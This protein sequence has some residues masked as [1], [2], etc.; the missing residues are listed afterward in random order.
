MSDDDFS[1]DGLTVGEVARMLNVHIQT[2]RRWSNQ[3]IVR[4]YRIGPRGD[5]RF[6]EEDV[7]NLLRK[8]D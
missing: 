1:L 6:R 8:P 2:I 4:V 5:R 3:G 7:I